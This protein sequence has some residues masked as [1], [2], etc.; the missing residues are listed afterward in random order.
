MSSKAGLRAQM[1]VGAAGKLRQIRST[2]KSDVSLLQNAP[3]Q[4]IAAQFVKVANMAAKLNQQNALRKMCEDY[5]K[6]TSNIDFDLKLKQEQNRNV[7]NQNSKQEIEP[8]ET[9]AQA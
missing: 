8:S 3:D 2:V 1:R 6:S 4:F 5:F 9:P 7:K